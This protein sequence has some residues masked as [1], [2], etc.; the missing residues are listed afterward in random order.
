MSLSNMSRT[1]YEK[2]RRMLRDNGDFAY[3]W[4]DCPLERQDMKD[5]KNER[6]FN[7]W[8]AERVWCAKHWPSDTAFRLTSSLLL[9]A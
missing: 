4:I 3:K 7:D 6:L 5:I 8:L 2:H 1:T 9:K